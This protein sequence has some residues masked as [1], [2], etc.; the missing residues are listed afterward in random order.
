MEVVIAGTTR[1]PIG[2]FGGALASKSAVDLG[3]IAA[4][5]AIA[6]A[7][8]DPQRINQAIFGN[9][10][11]A[12]S[13]QNVA[14][15]I[16]LNSGMSVSST[17]MTIN[18]VCGSGL[19]AIRLGQSAIMMGDA[20]VVLVG[21]TE[22]MSNV[23]YYDTSARWGHKYGNT[24][25]TD[26]L[27]RDGLSDAFSG[28]AMGVTAENVAAKYGVSRADQ[29]AWALRSH[30]RAVQATTNGAFAAEIAPVTVQTRKA[31]ITVSKDEGPR[32]D[33]S[34]EKLAHLKPS[35]KSDGTVTAG[36]ASGL[37]D[38]ASA[39]ILLRRDLADELGIKY[40]A[41]IDAYAEAGVDPQY[42]GYGPYEVVSSLF[43]KCHEEPTDVDLFE[44]NEA[45][46][47]QSVAVVRNLG[48]DS[49]RVNVDGGA[50]ALGH[51]LGDS[52]ARIVT[53]LIHALQRHG[54]QKGIAAL[55][56][57]GGLGV[58]LQ[59]HLVAANA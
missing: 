45:F 26:G 14:R 54:G 15:Q 31:T 24:Q 37:N 23:P 56:I 51:P 57:G 33:T 16:A 21:G 59:L 18:E 34:T 22:S 32:P 10:Y 29:D 27:V 25:L 41:V 4:K 48:L 19:K 7:G 47:A 12:G 43:A 28:V 8:I 53:T 55:C 52:G 17:A 30:Q 49:E 50:I 58:G 44:L 11:Q 38:G 42:M 35:F 9:V 13:G 6:R 1:T 36:N 3:V 2:K 5:T 20:D 46:A 40:E 39:M